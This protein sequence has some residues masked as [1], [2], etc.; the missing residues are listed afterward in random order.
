MNR[1][2]I[3]IGAAAI[4]LLAATAAQ[5]G[6]GSSGSSKS[7]GNGPGSPLACNFDTQLRAPEKGQLIAT[8][9]VTCN[10]PVASARTTLV[11]QGRKTGTDNTA[12]DNFDDPKPT[13]AVP[14]N[15]LTYAVTCIGGYDYQAS[16]DITGVS[17]NGAPF[18]ADETTPVVS[19]T[20]AECRSN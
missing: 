15:H 9:S 2:H 6:C 12:W 18:H 11:I 10:F 4:A 14:P 19:Y 13:T 8:S 3:T 16:A 20:T 5:G 7:G 17:A 1:K